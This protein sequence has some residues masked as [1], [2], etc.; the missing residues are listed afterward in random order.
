[1]LHRWW[2]VV[3]V[4]YRDMQFA[5]VR[6]ESLVV[7]CLQRIRNMN[8]IDPAKYKHI[9]FFAGAGMSAKSGV[10]TYRGRGDPE[11]RPLRERRDIRGR[12]SGSG[13]SPVRKRE[14]RP[15]H[16]DQSR[17]ERHVMPLRRGDPRCGGQGAAGTAGGRDLRGAFGAGVRRAAVTGPGNL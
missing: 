5:V 2:T 6:R 17:G 12:L 16:R 3:N 13:F 15:V 1:M 7:I 4:P 10:A 14:Q 11:L 8:P 9:V